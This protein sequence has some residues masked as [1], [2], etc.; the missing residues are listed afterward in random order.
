VVRVQLTA[1][2]ADLAQV[3][4]KVTVTLLDGTD[5]DGT[6]VTVADATSSGTATGG[7]GGEAGGGEAGAEASAASDE[8]ALEVTIA[9]DDP[10]AAEAYTTA[11]VDVLFTSSQ[12]ED[13]LTVP[14]TALLALL[15]GG[16]AVEI[17]AGDG[18]AGDTASSEGTTRL[19]E[20]EPGMFADGFVEVT[21]EGLSEG[22]EVVVPE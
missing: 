20:V 22:T 4:D 19:V 13:V 3:D 18:A 11:S 6:V 8:V 12:R 7:S 2:Q 16:Y 9:L 17:P 14:V 21:G 1:D 10:A 15:G 5:I